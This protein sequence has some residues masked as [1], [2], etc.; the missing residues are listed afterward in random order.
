MKWLWYVGPMVVLLVYL[1]STLRPLATESRWARELTRWLVE[2]IGPLP[3]GKKGESYRKASKK[4]RSRRVARL[5][6]A[7][8]AMLEQVGQGSGI[9]D[10]VLVPKL[11]YL[12]A[13]GAD[14]LNGSAHQTVFC[15]L[16]KA[17]P[18]MT[19]SPLPVIDGSAVENKGIT[20]SKD[21][22]FMEV[23]VVEGPSAKAIGKWLTADLREILME[24]PNVWLRTEGKV[25]AL[26]LYGETDADGVDELVAT[27]DALFAERGASGESLLGD[28][29]SV[30][31]LREND[32]RTSFEPA[33]ARERAIAG[34]IDMALYLLAAFAVSL[35]L[36]V[37][38]WFHPATGP[39]RASALS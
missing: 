3:G 13:R 6:A 7:F 17:A 11:A 27:A 28:A 35:T 18:T 30:G 21:P 25:M 22:E 19:V 16:A 9:L 23:F 5:P 20:F 39:P 29:D 10:A 38:P 12:A 34:A 24:Q 1:I 4:R 37:F 14:A 31:K 15:K 33:E 32:E 26:T 2:Y 36:G 8:A